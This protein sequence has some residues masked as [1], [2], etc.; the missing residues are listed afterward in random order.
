VTSP[1]YTNLLKSL[2]RQLTAN[3]ESSEIS[4]IATSL[5]VLANEKLK[6]EKEK[7]KK[8]TATK[9]S[10]VNMKNE[11]LEEGDYDEFTDFY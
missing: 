8:K 4:Q 10:Q 6:V 2:F 3:I 7:K 11:E 1:H 9:K 5:S